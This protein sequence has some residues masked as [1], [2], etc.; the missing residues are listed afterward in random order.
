MYCLGLGISSRSVFD[1]NIMVIINTK[2]DEMFVLYYS[3]KE[4]FYFVKV[5]C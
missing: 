5:A 4:F 1:M 2:Y 3:L